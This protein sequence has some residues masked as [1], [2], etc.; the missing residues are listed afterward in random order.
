MHTRGRSTSLSLNFT[1][2]RSDDGRTWVKRGIICIVKI[3]G[4]HNVIPY[5]APVAM[6]A[7]VRAQAAGDA[8]VGGSFTPFFA[9]SLRYVL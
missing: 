8:L 1:Y 7:A 6:V 4:T 9:S 2:F 5:A 3:G